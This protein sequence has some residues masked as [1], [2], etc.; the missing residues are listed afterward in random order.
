MKKTPLTTRILRII[1]PLIAVLCI[2]LWAPWQ[3]GL[4]YLSPLPDS[5]QEQLDDAIKYDL[6]GIIVYVQQADNAPE[7]YAAGFNNR[8]TKTPADPHVLFKIA[9]ISKLYIAAATAKLVAAQRLS[10]DGTLAE[11]LPELANRIEHAQSITLRMLVQHRS[12]IFNFTDDP[13]FP[14]DNMPTHSSEL[15]TFGLDKPAEFA[16]DESYQ[17][18]NTNYLLIGNILDKTL[19]YSHHR[20]ITEQILMPLGLRRT[21]NVPSEVNLAELSSGYFIGY[22]GDLKT[23]PHVGASGS[24]I[25]SAEDV[26][27]FLRALNDG[28]LLNEQEQAIYASIYVFEHTGL[29]PGYSSIARYHPDID[30]VVIQFVNTSGGNSWTTTEVIY[31]RIIKLLHQR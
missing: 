7:F 4:M 8:D 1:M 26:G 10:L 6:D 27:T 5:I 29:V 31:G 21:F 14:W 28:S 30:T 24:M 18:S 16:P 15:L 13:D 23:Q 17:Y 11:Y 9:S 25:A 20:Y 3:A 12:G 22:D 19:G 2:F